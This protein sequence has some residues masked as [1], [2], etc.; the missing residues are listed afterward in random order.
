LSWVTDFNV[1]Y[2]CGWQLAACWTAR[3]N[4][5]LS[6]PKSNNFNNVAGG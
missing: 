3:A 5:G 6:G 4:Q 2:L 1:H